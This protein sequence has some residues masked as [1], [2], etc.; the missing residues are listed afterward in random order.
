MCLIPRHP[1]HFKQGLHIQTR[2]W[3]PQAAQFVLGEAYQVLSDP[4]KRELYDKFGKEDMPKDLMH[5]AAAEHSGEIEE[6]AKEKAGEA[7]NNFKRISSAIWKAG[8]DEFLEWHNQ[9]LF[10]KSCSSFFWGQKKL[11]TIFQGAKPL[12]R[13]DSSLRSENMDMV[14]SGPSSK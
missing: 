6:I 11:G 4:E 13:R 5:P 9:K 14:D 2:T 3:D 12:Y 7:H 10:A 1:P 8:K